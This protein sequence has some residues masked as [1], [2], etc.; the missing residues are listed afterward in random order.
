VNVMETSGLGK[1][2]RSIWG[3]RDCTLAVPAGHIAALVGPNGAGKTTL[4]HCAVGLARPTTG[5]VTVFGHV[6]AGSLDALGRV[7]FVAQDAPLHR[8]LPVTA[9]LDL[10]RDLN[11]HFDRNQATQRL[12]SLEIPLHRKVGKL[13]GGQ[14]AQ[15]ALALALA[16]HPD[17]LV[18]DEPLA[19]LDPLARHDFLAHLMETVAEEGLSVVFSSHVVSELERAADYLVVLAGGR[20]QMAG[21]IDDLLA[22]HAMLS[23][24]ADEADRIRQLFPVV[25]AREAGRRISLLARTP[26]AAELPGGWDSDSVTLEELILA[27]LRDPSASILPGPFAAAARTSNRVSN[28]NA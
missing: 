3:L 10:S 5:R 17:L 1:R 27:Y 13:S 24:P 12:C 9:M 18:L 19:R 25:Q 26:V 6:P 14:Q 15:L 23:G 2:Y 21:V 28:D 7:A 20:V 16:R 4:L 22:A 8:Y 11:R